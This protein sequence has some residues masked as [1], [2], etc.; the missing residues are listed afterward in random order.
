MALFSRIPRRVA[1]GIAILS[2]VLLAADYWVDVFTGQVGDRPVVLDV[3]SERLGGRME[4]I[5]DA[6]DGT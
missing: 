6:Q 1:A 4:P 2:A 3:R 5:H